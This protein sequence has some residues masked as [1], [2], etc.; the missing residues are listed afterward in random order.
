MQ[1]KHK[2]WPLPFMSGLSAQQSEHCQR[3]HLFAKAALAGKNVM[4]VA[5]YYIVMSSATLRGVCVQVNV[6]VCVCV[7][8]CMDVRVCVLTHSYFG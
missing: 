5:S 6:R 7:C 1:Y 2:D 8:V 4:Y 3:P